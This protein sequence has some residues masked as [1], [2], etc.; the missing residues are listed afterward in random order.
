MSYENIIVEKK[1][2]VFVLTL[3]RPPLNILNIKMMNEINMALEEVLGWKECKILLIKGEGKAF[4]A[5]AD[6]GEHL[7]EKVNEMLKTFHKM[8]YLLDLFEGI[9]VSAVNGSA[10][11]GGC[12]LALFCDMVLASEKAKF[13]QPEIKLG[14]FPPVAVA[15]YPLVFPS[16]F[17]MDF[18]LSGEIIDATEAEKKGLINKI[19]SSERFYEEVDEYLK[20]FKSLS[21]SSLKITKTVIKKIIKLDFQNNLKFADE[22][23]LTILMKTEDANEGLKAF[24]EKR[25]PLWKNK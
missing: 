13:G 5:G 10:L 2:D 15:L 20:K 21:L 6:V 25:E 23:Y 14:V 16:R 24:L 18:I 22:D 7:P 1:D 19:I 11:G 4:S 17:I 3:N 9:S 12:E 8:F